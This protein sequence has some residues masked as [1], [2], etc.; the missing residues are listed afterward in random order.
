MILLNFQIR[1]NRMLQAV[2]QRRIRV[3][4]LCE[5][6]YSCSGVGHASAWRA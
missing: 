6:L 5:R 4:I 1:I 3:M 2:S